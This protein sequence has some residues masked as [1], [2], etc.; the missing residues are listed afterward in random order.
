MLSSCSWPKSSFWKYEISWF[1]SRTST[2]KNLELDYL[3]LNKNKWKLRNFKMESFCSEIQLTLE[4]VGGWGCWLP[5]V[6]K[7][8]RLALST[9]SYTSMDSTNLELCSTTVVHILWKNTCISW[10]HRVQTHFDQGST[11]AAK[12]FSFYILILYENTTWP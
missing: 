12:F 8:M 1:F 7:H 10:T 3:F 6:V 9:H 5:S 11:E 2:I 4:Q